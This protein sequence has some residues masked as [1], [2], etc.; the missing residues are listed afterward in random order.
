MLNDTRITLRGNV[1]TTP[2]LKVTTAGTTLCTFR[3]AVT[4]R[5]WS[6]TDQKYVDGATSWYT[7]TAWRGL[8]GNVAASLAPGTGVV[9]QGRLRIRDYTWENQPR[10]SADV[11]ADVVALDLSWG[12]VKLEPARRR[13][14]SSSGERSA[15]RAEAEILAAQSAAEV[16][17]ESRLAYEAAEPDEGLGDGDLGE[18][19]GEAD[20]GTTEGDA[21]SLAVVGA[22]DPF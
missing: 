17:E 1:A 21:P 7:V 10:T 8:A 4:D 18:Q 15:D 22:A 12:T 6:D 16:T 19:D 14:G 13:G 9:V 11:T 5:R 20:G 3:M 2:S